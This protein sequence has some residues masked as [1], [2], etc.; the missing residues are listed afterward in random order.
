MVDGTFNRLYLKC[1]L[2]PDY[3]LEADRPC[4]EIFSGS[5]SSR[6]FVSPSF[7]PGGVAKAPE[8]EGPAAGN[9]RQ[10]ARHGRE[11]A[12]NPICCSV[13]ESPSSSLHSFVVDVQAIDREAGHEIRHED[14][15]QT[16]SYGTVE[17][18]RGALV[19]LRKLLEIGRPR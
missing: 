1:T 2:S 5:G 9:P 13:D 3:F 4:R 17:M 11:T 18:C 6:F 15:S 16:V 8:G 19:R 7:A 14:I 10:Y 12:R